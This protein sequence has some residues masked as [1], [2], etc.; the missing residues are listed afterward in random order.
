MTNNTKFYAITSMGKY[1]K[2]QSIQELTQILSEQKETDIDMYVAFLYDR[3]YITQG[4]NAF[5]WPQI[6]IID[7]EGKPTIYQ[8]GVYR[9]K[10]IYPDR[11]TSYFQGRTIIFE[12]CVT[13]E[14]V[15]RQVLGDRRFDATT[16]ELFYTSLRDI[17]LELNRSFCDK[18]IKNNN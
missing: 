10:W 11:G 18:L 13:N 9:V 6:N 8:R 14:T 17:L 5:W 15:E 12:N 7:K 2:A 1:V 4:G 3:P 16:I